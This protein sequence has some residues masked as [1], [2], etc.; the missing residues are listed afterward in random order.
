MFNYLSKNIST[1]PSGARTL[2]YHAKSIF[3]FYFIILS[4]FRDINYLTVMVV[5]S[6]YLIFC[7]S[8]Y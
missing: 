4:R 1:S 7:R 8:M 5:I 2:Q 6:I 3:S